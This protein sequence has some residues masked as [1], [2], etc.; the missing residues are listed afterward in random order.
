M[1]DLVIKRTDEGR[2]LLSE[3]NVVEIDGVEYKVRHEFVDSMKGIK[4]K[5]VVRIR[6]SR[7]SLM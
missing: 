1:K 6:R 5:R 7:L 2:K 4:L 3:E